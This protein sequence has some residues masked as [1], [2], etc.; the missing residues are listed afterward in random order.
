MRAN[1]RVGHGVGR[2]RLKDVRLK[3]PLSEM[4]T[5]LR[6][7]RPAIEASRSLRRAVNGCIPGML[8]LLVVCTG[9]AS[10]QWA[11]LRRAP[12]NPLAQTLQ[13]NSYRGPRPTART[14]QFL[15]RYDL[16]EEQE[17]DPGEL[18]NRAQ[19]IS[20]QEP[21][22][23]NVYAVAE[24]AYIGAKRLETQN[25][26]TQALDL[27]GAAVA[28]AYLYLL[29]GQFNN[30]RNP[31]DPRFRQACDIYNS[32][33]EGA[34]RQAQQ[35]GKL[36]PG[37]RYTVQ[38]GRQ[39][40]DISV[41]SRGP[42]HD[43][44]F[45]ELKFASDFEVQ[46]LSN[47]YQTYGLGVPMIAVYRTDH[48][49]D[50]AQP[51]Y[52]PGMA[53]PVTA[54]LRVDRQH[55][56][57]LGSGGQ[58]HTCVLELYDP[59]QATDVDVDARLVPLETDLTT[60]LAYCLDNQLFKQA[61]APLEGLLRPEQAK[62]V[63]GLYMLEVYDPKKI[64]VIMVHGFWSSLVTW[65]EMFNDLR[66]AAEIRDRY[67]FWFY[68]YPTGQPFWV[69]A[70]QLREDLRKA[71]QVLDPQRQSPSLDQMV[72]V[73]HSMGGLIAKL[74]TLES[75]DDYWHLLS[76]RP[77]AEL[78]GAPEI[79]EAL[80]KIVY[81][82]PNPSVRRV[83]TI[84]TPHRGTHFSNGTTQWLGRQLIDVGEHELLHQQ[85]LLDQNSRFFRDDRL[86][87]ITTSVDSL[88]PDSPFLPLMLQSAHLPGV[89]YHN[90]L[91]QYPEKGLMG[92]VARD[93]DGVVTTE[94][95]TLQVADSQIVVTS[96]HVNVHRHPRTILEVRRVLL[97]HLQSPLPPSTR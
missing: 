80:A 27:Y 43:G 44:N 40:F 31:Y 62:A 7:H 87:G 54:L 41:K 95:A 83:I 35:Q 65:M 90:V 50:A 36:V 88:S 92:K 73:G 4:A 11:R 33:L 51:Y 38:T 60:P 49:S 6:N 22:A 1:T 19:Q 34:M 32:S 55:H 63:Q 85:A 12:R 21:L 89:R 47:H 48:Q 56:R 14:A 13:L 81:F 94:S 28:N 68:H 3:E 82:E 46:G 91:G 26:A 5:S 17:S 57:D 64:P 79:K 18:L 42:W 74:Q 96:D 15:R 25:E 86:L 20:A 9:C 69:T 8:L 97:E 10:V 77:F 75:R 24:L 59:L 45:E 2:E 66:G 53:F 72:L 16:I 70:A 71:R 37:Q 58:R 78:Q 39:T 23:D 93:S 30:T 61:K 29:D 52:P 76:S 84:A 67:Q